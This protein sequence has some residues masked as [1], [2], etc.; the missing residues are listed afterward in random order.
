M[1][2]GDSQVPWAEVVVF[3]CARAVWGRGQELWALGGHHPREQ[4]LWAGG[5]QAAAGTG[6]RL[7]FG[8]CDSRMGG[9]LSH[10]AHHTRLPHC[11]DAVFI[12]PSCC[13]ALGL[14]AQ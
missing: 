14:A 4:S 12:L 2:S 8:P 5:H 3:L 9:G 11:L 13:L 10:P 7:P 1:V 6:P